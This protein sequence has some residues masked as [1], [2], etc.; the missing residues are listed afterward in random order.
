[1]D[2]LEI[3]EAKEQLQELIQKASLEN[4]QYRVTSEKG[5]VI[6]LPEETY[7]NILVTLELLST[8]GLLDNVKWP[9][10]QPLSQVN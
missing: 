3:T 10:E 7:N 4:T 5:N 2:T 6:I 1:M 9:E 8:P